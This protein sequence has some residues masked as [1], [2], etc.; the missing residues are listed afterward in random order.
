MDGLSSISSVS[1]N[2]QASQIAISHFDQSVDILRVPFSKYGRPSQQLSRSKSKIILKV[3]TGL[4]CPALTSPHPYFSTCGNLIA[5]N[6]KIHATQFQSNNSE[7]SQVLALPEEASNA[8]FFGLERFILFSYKGCVTLNHSKFH[9]I[10]DNIVGFQDPCQNWSFPGHVLALQS[11]NQ[12]ISDIVAVS[13]SDNAIRIIDVETGKVSWSAHNKTGIKNAHSL[14]L[15][16]TSASAYLPSETYNLVAA[17]SVSEGG[18]VVLFDLRTSKEIFKFRE[19]VNRKDK[20]G[21]SFSPCM[22][23]IASGNEAEGGAILYD[24]RYNAL[25]SRSILKIDAKAR[26]GR[27]FLD[28]PV[29]CVAFNPIYPQLITGS[30]NGHLRFYT[31]ES[32]F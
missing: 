31:E 7:L 11:I 16:N 28:G 1:F 4:R 13:T 27:P 15:P 22:R 24:L 6:N 32:Y 26:C 17:G 9:H 25:S 18:L 2:Y 23:Y 8:Q 3:I 12:P 29:T 20:C 10:D 14:A 5:Y 21:I 30:L 19:H